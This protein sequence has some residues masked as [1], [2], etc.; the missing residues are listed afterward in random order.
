MAIVVNRFKNVGHGGGPLRC[1]GIA[2]PVGRFNNHAN[3]I[4]KLHGHALYG[5]DGRRDDRLR[6][7]IVARIGRPR[8]FEATT[9]PTPGYVD[10]P[11][12]GETEPCGLQNGGD[13]RA[14]DIFAALC[15]AGMAGCIK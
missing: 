6:A 9:R 15:P 8:E 14:D 3:V 11:D 4:G 7:E 2:L 5:E 10:L 13:G 12:F 1:C